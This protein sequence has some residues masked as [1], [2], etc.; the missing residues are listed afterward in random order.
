MAIKLSKQQTSSISNNSAG[1]V[2]G[3]PN[4]RALQTALGAGAVGKGQYGTAFDILKSD[5]SGLSEEDKKRQAALQRGEKVLST[6]ED[7]YFKNKLHKGMSLDG[8][9]MAVTGTV[10]RNSPYFRY[11]RALKSARVALAKTAGEVGNL[12]VQEQLAQ[13][14]AVPDALYDRNN[15]IEQFNLLRS[16]LGL[17]PRKY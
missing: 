15:A 9:M 6:I 2:A 16:N 11:K 7:Y 14:K 5:I 4:M 1:G 8:L 13:E 12:A 3:A 10:D 17:K